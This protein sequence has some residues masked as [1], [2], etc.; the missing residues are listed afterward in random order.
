[1]RRLPADIWRITGM[2][3]AVVRMAGSVTREDAAAPGLECEGIRQEGH[4]GE[5]EVVEAKHRLED[6]GI[7]EDERR[8]AL[9][10]L[11]GSSMSRKT[12]SVGGKISSWR[13]TGALRPARLAKGSG[14][15]PSVCRSELCVMA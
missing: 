12:P 6:V 13:L 2:Y 9:E 14:C 11:R 3:R 4:R 7:H 1:M 15:V 10:Q 8:A 5:E